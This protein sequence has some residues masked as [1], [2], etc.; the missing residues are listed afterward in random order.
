MAMKHFCMPADFRKE[1]IDAY[2]RLNEQYPECAVVETYGNVTVENCF[3]SGRDLDKLPEVDLETLA[4][5]A[6][7]SRSKGI[8]F[9]YTINAPYMQNREF[10]P[11][12]VAEIRRFLGKLHDAGIRCLIIAMPSLMEVVL[13][14]GYEFEIKAS[15][16]AQITNPNKAMMFK[17]LGVSRLTVDESITREFSRL[18]H[19]K[20]TFHGPVEIIV[21][22]ICLQDCHFRPFH[23]NQISGD[24][25]DRANPVSCNYFTGRCMKRLFDDLSNY[26]KASWI[27][28]EDLHYYTDAGIE[29]FKIQ[30][31]Q[32]VLNGDPV[33]AVE[34]YFNE[35]Y[36]GDL[37]DLMFLFSPREFFP[38]K[39][40][41]R[42][43]DGF[44]KPFTRSDDFCPRDCTRCDYCEKYARRIFGDQNPEQVVAMIREKIGASDPFTKMMSSAGEGE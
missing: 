17:K 21:N 13:R 32:S 11:E 26:F 42:A 2:A 5:Y 40:D 27:R 24:S 8:E 34:C 29:H 10:T 19:I 7:Y 23:Y 16:I 43:L 18:R 30:G 22:S 37:T 28:P 25:V 44:L 6:A 12:G 31:R 41:N 33:R 14:S 38:F 9:A 39:V 35:R 3:G 4:D 20:E 15:V 1:T 36:D